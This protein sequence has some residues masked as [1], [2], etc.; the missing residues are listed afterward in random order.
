M[1]QTRSQKVQA[2]QTEPLG[3]ISPTWMYVVI[4][5]IVLFVFDGIYNNRFHLPNHK[6]STLSSVNFCE[7][8]YFLSDYVAE[9]HNTWSSLVG[10]SLLPFIALLSSNPTKEWRFTIM[11]LILM[12]IGIGS[13]SL[14]ATLLALPQS[15]DEVPMLWMIVIFLFALLENSALPNKP[16]YQYLPY[17]LL[18]A[19]IVQTGVYYT[20]MQYYSVFLLNYVSMAAV[21][22][23]WIS[24]LA[25][26]NNKGTTTNGLSKKLWQAA[27][28]SYLLIGTPLWIVE[29]NNCTSLLPTYKAFGGLSFHIFW[30][31]GAG[32]G[33]YLTILFFI[34]LRMQ[35]I[36]GEEGKLLYVFGFCPIVE[37]ANNMKKK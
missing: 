21:V 37:R 19:G 25:N 16:H 28:G 35:E 10:I 32:L 36:Y 9:F 12:A 5:A 26:R 1:V 8:D 17:M 31:F 30:H 34:S 7:P 3:F 15:F 14:H 23:I 29:M 20:F 33:T 6:S 4:I 11:Y 2:L 27:I 22:I 24:H 18:V 13:A